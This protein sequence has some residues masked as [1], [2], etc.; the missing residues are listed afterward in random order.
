VNLILRYILIFDLLV[1]F[2]VHI[3]VSV[4]DWYGTMYVRF[5]PGILGADFTSPL[6]QSHLR[7]L[8]LVVKT[9]SPVVTRSKLILVDPPCRIFSPIH[10]F[11]LLL[12]LTLRLNLR[13]FATPSSLPLPSSSPILLIAVA[14]ILIRSLSRSTSPRQA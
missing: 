11:L 1:I 12:N 6:F 4:T 8:P 2:L 7:S 3:T 14:Q 13:L 10:L 5:S 9:L